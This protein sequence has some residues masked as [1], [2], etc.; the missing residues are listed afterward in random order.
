MHLPLW[1]SS[2]NFVIEVG[3]VTQ[4]GGYADQKSGSGISPFLP[5]PSDPAGLYLPF[6]IFLFTTRVPLLLTVALAYFL[7]LQW[8]PIGVFGKKAALWTILGVPGIWWIDLQIDGV[9]KGYASHYQARFVP[10]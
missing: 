10:C 2:R 6:H 9:K 7:V 3:Q 8:L 1:R 5:I 4:A